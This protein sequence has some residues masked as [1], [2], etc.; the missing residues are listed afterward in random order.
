MRLVDIIMCAFI[1]SAVHQTPAYVLPLDLS[2]VVI[3]QT[4]FISAEITRT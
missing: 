2:L 4:A 3:M 1:I